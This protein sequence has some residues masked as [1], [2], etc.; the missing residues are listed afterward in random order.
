MMVSG[1]AHC[2]HRIVMEFLPAENRLLQERLRGRRIRFADAERALLARKAK[3][4]GRKSPARTRHH[5]LSGYSVAVASALGCA[6]VELRRATKSW[7]AFGRLER[8]PRGRAHS[9]N[10]GPNGA[11]SSRL[12]AHHRKRTTATGWRPD[13]RGVN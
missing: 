2:H 7:P 4:V 10:P 1:W 12:A 11:T 5:S 8:A 9:R 13:T 6:E 3:A